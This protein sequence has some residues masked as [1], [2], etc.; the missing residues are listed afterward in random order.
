MALIGSREQE[1]AVALARG[2]FRSRLRAWLND[3]GDR[4]LAQRVA[5]TAF[6]IR[7]G[8]AALAFLSQVLLARWMG[9]HEFGIYVY[10]STWVMVVGGVVD[11]GI[12]SSAQ[13]FIPQ[14]SEKGAWSLLRGFLSGGRWLVFW[15]ATTIAI[16]GLA[17]IYLL[18]GWLDDYT[19]VPLAIGCIILPVYGVMHVQDGIAR[20][21]NWPNL[22]L[23]PPF[24]F[25][26][27]I[28]IG[29]MGAAF[30]TG[31]ATDAT[32][33]I[34]ISALAI[35]SCAIG[36]F[37]VLSRKLAREVPPG[38]KSYDIPRWVVVS[39]PMFIV[40]CIYVLLM[41]VDVLILKQFRSPEEIAVYYAAAKT[42][43]LVSFVYFAVAA[44]S[45]HKFSEYF[46]AGDRPRL[47]SFVRDAIRWAFWPSLAACALVLALGWPLLRLFGERF[48]S[49]YELMFILSIGILARAAIGPGERF[50]SMVGEQKACALAALAALVVN[51]LLC[52]ALI[53]AYGVTGA[54][55]STTIAFIVESIL[56]FLI[57]KYRLGFHLFVI[58]GKSA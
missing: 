24:V 3:H 49:G 50:L 53:P 39:I 40:D 21:Y 38:E 37:L 11:I 51:L 47:A 33:A 42:M 14:Y 20:S 1:E 43:A 52:F 30:A 22:A 23:M 18:R 29:L 41:Y 32:I 15:I 48:V 19:I 54:A 13:R 25:R 8:A 17:A 27:L 16:L 57:A 4:S 28:V 36:Q 35:W 34:A 12:A 56:I 10:V 44:A 6:L 5:S 2:A 31:I 9:A 45:A 58:G 46:E 7:V 55:F 26:Q